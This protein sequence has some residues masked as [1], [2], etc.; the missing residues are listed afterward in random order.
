M[1]SGDLVGRYQAARGSVASLLLRQNLG[2]GKGFLQLDWATPVL[3]RLGGLKFHVQFTS[4]YGETLI[5]Y[6]H[7][8]TTLG[9]GVSFGDW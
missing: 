2:S 4:G 7:H 8:Q 6:N 3:Q 9:A 5:D 1:G